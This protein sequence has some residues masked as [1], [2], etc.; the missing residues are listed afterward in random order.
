[1]NT[2]QINVAIVGAS[3]LVGRTMVK[4]LDERNFPINRLELFATAKSAGT[5]LEYKGVNITVNDISDPAFQ[6]RFKGCEISLFSGGKDASVNYAP[7]AVRYGSIVIDNGSY[8]RMNP[9]VP[10]VVPEVN[11]EEIEN[12]KGILANPNCSTIQLVVALQPIHKA[13]GLKRVI[14]ST[15]QSITGAGQKGL[16]QLTSEIKNE[17]PLTPVSKHKIAYNA[18]FHP[19]GA[20]SGFTV[21]EI[22]M[23]EE[24]RKIMNLPWLAISV[25]CV[26]L[27]IVGGHGESVNIETEK[28]F[29]E[30]ELKNVLKDSKG[31]VVMDDLKNEIYPTPQYAHNTDNV[32][33]G[34]IRKDESTANGAYLWVVADNVRKGAATNAIQIAE[35]L[36]GKM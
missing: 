7:L 8:W 32:Y 20:L 31:I 6:S 30:T 23:I 3:G 16:D 2:K 14:V 10:L 9:D 18:V 24:T 25:T 26:R 22:K 27:P 11:P 36:S 21:E 13:F 4:L 29:T 5:V 17:T 35:I 1:M 15:Y 28:P 12:H 19:A 34:R 33:V